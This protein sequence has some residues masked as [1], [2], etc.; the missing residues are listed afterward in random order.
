VLKAFIHSHFTITDITY[1]TKENVQST[2]LDP[3]KKHHILAQIK[4]LKGIISSNY[5]LVQTELHSTEDDILILDDT[6]RWLHEE[7]GSSASQVL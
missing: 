4:K 1:F 3:N 2:E 5:A 6:L 7:L